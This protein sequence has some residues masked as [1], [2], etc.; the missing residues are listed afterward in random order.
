M[1]EKIVA[2][3]K[4]ACID[5]ARSEDLF[6]THGVE[7]EYRNVLTDPAAAA[8]LETLARVDGN[9]GKPRIIF[10]RG[11][12]EEDMR[13]IVTLIEPSDDLLTAVLQQTGYI[14]QT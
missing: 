10:Y 9:P 3:V 13:P 4:T 11:E 7:P 14:P 2:Y 8:E 12:S 1:P 6:R 5:C